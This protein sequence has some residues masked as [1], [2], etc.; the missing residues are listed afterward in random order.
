MK[1]KRLLVTDSS[2]EIGI[3]S[4]FKKVFGVSDLEPVLSPVKIKK[5]FTGLS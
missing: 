2:K 5:S 4:K 1:T 3:L